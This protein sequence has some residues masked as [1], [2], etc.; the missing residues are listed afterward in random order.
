LRKVVSVVFDVGIDRDPEAGD[1]ACH[2]PYA[3]RKR[4]RMVHVMDEGAADKRRDHVPN[5]TNHRSPK[6]TTRKPWTARRC[7]IG[8]RTHAARVGEYLAGGDENCK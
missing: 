3:K 2:K 6:L 7:I 4:P 5:S 1:N 8:G